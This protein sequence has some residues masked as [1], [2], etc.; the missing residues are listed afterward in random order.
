MRLPKRKLAKIAKEYNLNLIVLFGSYATHLPKRGSDID[1]AIR[2]TR[3]L[4]SKEEIAL[5]SQ[6]SLLFPT[7]IDVTF[8]NE[9]DSVLIYEIARDGIPLYEENPDSFV[10]FQLYATKV[11]E[12]EQKYRELTKE[13][14]LKGK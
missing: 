3:H 6:L 5:I 12:D 8:I 13:Y 10:E 1:I 9:A 7:E 14:V 11:S 4:T 2:T